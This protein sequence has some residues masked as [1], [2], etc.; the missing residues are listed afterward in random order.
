MVKFTILA[1]TAAAHSPHNKMAT[2]TI[3]G[4]ITSL[5]KCT[6]ISFFCSSNYIVG[7]DWFINQSRLIANY[8]LKAYLKNTYVL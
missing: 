3:A 6:S 2:A 7:V 4:K 8:D 5:W 1:A